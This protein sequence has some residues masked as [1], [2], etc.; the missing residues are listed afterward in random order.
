MLCPFSAIAEFSFMYSNSVQQHKILPRGIIVLTVVPW[1]SHHIAASLQLHNTTPRRS[2]AALAPF[3]QSHAIWG[4]LIKMLL[5][6][7]LIVSIL[8][9]FAN[10]STSSQASNKRAEQPF[11]DFTLRI[12]N[13]C[14][15][16]MCWDKVLHEP[17]HLVSLNWRWGEHIYPFAGF[18]QISLATFWKNK[19]Y[20]KRKR[21]RAEKM[22]NFWVLWFRCCKKLWKRQRFGNYVQKRQ[23]PCKYWNICV[24]KWGRTPKNSWLCILCNRWSTRNWWKN[25]LNLK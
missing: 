6:P 13:I 23:V 10:R 19:P 16:I 4:R 18:L 2:S 12:I 24:R 9:Y 1:V 14:S 15:V 22:W 20:R 3:K 7:L 11:T 21:G 5:K 8:K 17:A 25:N